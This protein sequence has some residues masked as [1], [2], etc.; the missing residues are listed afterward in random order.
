[1]FETHSTQQILQP[2]QSIEERVPSEKILPSTDPQEETQATMKRPTSSI[3]HHP[4]DRVKVVVKGIK[5]DDNED[6]LKVSVK[7]TTVLKLS[8]ICSPDADDEV[9]INQL[10]CKVRD[11]L[12]VVKQDWSS[13]EESQKQQK[14]KMKIEMQPVGGEEPMVQEFETTDLSKYMEHSNRKEESKGSADNQPRESKSSEAS[15][16]AKLPGSRPLAEEEERKSIGNQ[17][18]AAGEKMKQGMQL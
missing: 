7:G 16:T 2:Q 6:R 8:E 3:I 5:G 4:N 1:M 17:M 15:E 13:H 10:E 12:Q 14:Y 11:L 18:S 9:I